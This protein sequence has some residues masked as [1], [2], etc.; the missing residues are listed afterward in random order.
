[1]VVD[2]PHFD[3]LPLWD[4]DDVFPVLSVVVGVGEVGGGDHAGSAG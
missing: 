2:D 1:M 3:D 4:L